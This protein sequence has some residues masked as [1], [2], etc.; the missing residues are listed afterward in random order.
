MY[1]LGE[2]LLA[3]ETN[4]AKF[5][6]AE[7]CVGVASGLDALKIS[8]MCLDLKPDDEILVPANTYIATWL[9]ITFANA[10]I[11]PVEPD[12]ETGNVTWS[13]FEAKIT[14]MTK[15]IITVH[16]YGNVAE[17]EEIV[18][19]GKERNIYTVEDAAQAHGSSLNGKK[20]GVH[21]DF[22]CWSFYP[23]K[24]LGA[25]GDAGGI[26]TSN[27]KFAEKARSLRNYGSSKKYY[28]DFIGLNSRMD[29]IQAAILN[30]KL[31]KISV[32]QEIRK[33]QA[34]FYRKELTGIVSMFNEVPG[35]DNA[36]HLM[37]IL[38]T[39][40]NQLVEYLT[41]QGIGT[42]IHYPVP[43][44]LQNCYSHLGFKCGDFPITEKIASSVMSLPLGPHIGFTE[45][46]KVTTTIMNFADVYIGL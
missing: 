15:V 22:V 36:Y 46:K 6:D 13:N 43:P 28:N 26:T 45:C 23:G 32:W 44:H 4:Y 37:P 34:E 18:K 29:P 2:E 42:I 38:T 11:R 5:V 10:K 41:K 40:R 21:S 12:L 8:L 9:A 7:H 27:P 14:P 17:I 25:F 31:K 35:S 33:K 39:K 16:L 19:N 1:I 24:N 30:I 20:I 3:F